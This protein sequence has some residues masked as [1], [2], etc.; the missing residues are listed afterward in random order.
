MTKNKHGVPKSGFQGCLPQPADI[1]E[2]PGS[3]V[4]KR[5]A[6]TKSCR[7]TDAECRT[8][9][10]PNDRTEKSIKYT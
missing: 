4:I 7:M 10:R 3:G 8:F 1:R 2:N 5:D 6:A 9:N